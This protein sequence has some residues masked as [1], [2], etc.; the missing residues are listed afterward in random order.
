[1]SQSM[2]QAHMNKNTH[3]SLVGRGVDKLSVAGRIRPIQDRAR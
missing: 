1:M 2:V 3:H